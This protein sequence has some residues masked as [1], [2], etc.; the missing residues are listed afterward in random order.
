M[1]PTSSFKLVLILVLLGCATQS[2]VKD[3]IDFEQDDIQSSKTDN[4]I[5]YGEALILG[6]QLENPFSVDN[7][8]RA[9]N[10]LQ[11]TERQA[12]SIPSQIRIN[13]THQ[14]IKL[15]LKDSVDLF[16]IEADTTLVAYDHPLDYEIIQ[17]GDFY[18]DPEVPSNQPTPHY[19]AIRVGQTLPEGVQYE[20]LSDLYLPD[21]AVIGEQ[22]ANDL[23]DTAMRLT[24]N[25]E[26][27]S[28]NAE[29]E[30]A[31]LF[32]RRRKWRPAG[33]IQVWDDNIGSTTTYRQV[34]SH[35]ETYDCEEDDPFDDI[36]KR[37][38][39]IRYVI[40]ID[41]ACK[42]AVYKSVK[43][44]TAGGYVPMEGV[45][46][47][48]RRWFRTHT[49]ITNAQ[50]YYSCNGR[51]R[52]KAR[53]LIKWKRH[54]FTIRWSWLSAAKNRGPRKRG[55]WNLNIKGGHQEFYA[56]I[57]R[58]AHHYY[59]KDIKGLR[60]PPQNR[61]WRTKLK[62]KGKY[63]NKDINGN[64]KPSRRFLG[65]GSAIKIYNPH[66]E[67]QAIYSTVIHELAHAAHW[68]MDRRNYNNCSNPKVAESW[69]RGVEW[70]IDQNG[71]SQLL[72][73]RKKYWRLY[74]GCGGYDR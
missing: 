58:A 34:F 13:T 46:V 6:K 56:T 73:A 69:A 60:R 40:P 44:T 9:L 53:Y 52:G 25:F 8:E 47:R 65:L 24:G 18:H 29:R 55:N 70:G 16:K 21:A 38:E 26:V 12:T 50:G 61:S 15:I 14:Y 35:Y 20:V 42:R 3:A 68:R 62:I 54:Q 43:V 22:L 30:T 48:A 23:E 51:Y 31:A 72:G 28:D 49:G 71:I 45:K 67:T 74:F 37:Y 11:R 17:N 64:H 33:R 59:Y 5:P 41:K 57:F 32:K 63:E 2:C 10:T 39:D 19:A 36:S 7:M 1:T 4:N 27:E 66:R